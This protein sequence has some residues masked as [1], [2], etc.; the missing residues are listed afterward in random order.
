[1]EYIPKS[2]IA[3]LLYCLNWHTMDLI[4]AFHDQANGLSDQERLDLQDKIDA[5]RALKTQVLRK[6]VGEGHAFINGVDVT[7]GSSGITPESPLGAT[8][9]ASAEAEKAISMQ[10]AA[11]SIMRNFIDTSRSMLV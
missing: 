6:L 2:E 3:R 4:S 11:I 7:R 10:N 5:C 1:M 9:S 8:L